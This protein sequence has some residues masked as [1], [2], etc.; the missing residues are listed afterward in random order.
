MM[1][2]TD[3]RQNSDA[4]PALSPA[5]RSVAG[6]IY[7]Y[8]KAPSGQT[9]CGYFDG[10]RLCKLVEFFVKCEKIEPPNAPGERPG[11]KA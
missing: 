4:F 5:Q 10:P 7:A 8:L 3:Q 1:P 11:G 9:L 2:T 6:P